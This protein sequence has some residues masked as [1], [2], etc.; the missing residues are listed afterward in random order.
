[1][2]KW[3]YLTT[4]I[5][6]NIKNK[7]TQS[8]LKQRFPGRRKMPKFTPEAMMPELDKLGE[9]GWELIH[10]EPVAR[11]G[12]KGDILFPAGPRWTNHYFCVFKR[13][14]KTSTNGTPLTAETA[15]RQP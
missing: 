9:E 13:L 12:G 14:K 11:V 2:D 8:F 7:E 6:A 15:L 10:M 1:M 3:E 5:E 4:F